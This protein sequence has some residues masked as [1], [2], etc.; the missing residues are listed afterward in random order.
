MYIIENKSHC[1]PQAQSYYSCAFNR[2]LKLK[3]KLE[4]LI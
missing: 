4:I 2:R 3:L 1:V